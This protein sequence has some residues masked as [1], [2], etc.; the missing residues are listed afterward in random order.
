MNK[1][2]VQLGRKDGRDCG[3]KIKQKKQKNEK[4][5]KNEKKGLTNRNE[6]GIIDNANRTGA[7]KSLGANLPVWRNRQ[8]PGT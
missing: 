8:T 4:N 3:V 7:Q 6:C 5:I 1:Q 2:I